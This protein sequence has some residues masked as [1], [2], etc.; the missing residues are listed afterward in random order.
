[1][2]LKQ[3]HSERLGSEHAK[4]RHAKKREKQQERPVDG[5]S[6]LLASF[7]FKTK[8]SPEAAR[9]MV[10]K[11]RQT[12]WAPCTERRLRKL[13]IWPVTYQVASS[14]RRPMT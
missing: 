11:Q 10:P 12:G 9:C 2:A 14:L 7:F 8:I 5:Q 3:G 6:F 13:F 1:M 4:M